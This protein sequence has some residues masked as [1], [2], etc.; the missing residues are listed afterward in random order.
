MD[1]I[2]RL[3]DPEMYVDAIDDAIHEIQGLR[4]KLAELRK[5]DEYL[6][7][8]LGNCSDAEESAL[9]DIGVLEQS[10]QYLFHE[11]EG[12]E[13]ALRGCHDEVDRRRQEVADLERTLDDLS[14]PWVSVS[15]G[16]PGERLVLVAFEPVG[17]R[18]S[19]FAL[20]W[21][22]ERRGWRNHFG[23]SVEHVTHWMTLP[24]LPGDGG[25]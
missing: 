24:G 19:K 6:E 15:F 4:G 22:S 7:R 5:H 8:A 25:S 9:S 21:H 13:A 14:D 1:I 23:L 18:K 2:G 16:M 11:N 10:A 12:L 3:R 17:F 20:A